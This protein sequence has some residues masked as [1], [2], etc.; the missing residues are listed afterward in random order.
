MCLFHTTKHIAAF[1]WKNGETQSGVFCCCRFYCGKNTF[2]MSSSRLLQ[3][4]MK[5]RPCIRRFFTTTTTTTNIGNRRGICVGSQKPVKYQKIPRLFFSFFPFIMFVIFCSYFIFFLLSLSSNFFSHFS[6]FLCQ[7]F[8]ISC[9]FFF[10]LFHVFLFSF[11]S[12]FHVFCSCFLLFSGT[13]NLI[14]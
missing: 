9:F 14:F 10:S 6:L 8:K 13:G 7:F 11:V 4:I 2:L 12:V 1:L 5:D 3:K